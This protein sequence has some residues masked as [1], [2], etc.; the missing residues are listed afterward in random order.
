LLLND[1]KYLRHATTKI[2]TTTIITTI[3]T[4]TATIITTIT[5]Q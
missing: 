4:T 5:T 1:Q 2:P 3:T